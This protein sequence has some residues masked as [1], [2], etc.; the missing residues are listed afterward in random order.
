MSKLQSI[1]F[2][3]RTAEFRAGSDTPSAYLEP[4]LATIER[5]EPGIGA[6]VSLNTSSP[7]SPRRRLW[8]VGRIRI[9]PEHLRYE[10]ASD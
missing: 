3:S 9:V 5:L 1:P 4:R 2:H 6:F 10:G 7:L 8:V